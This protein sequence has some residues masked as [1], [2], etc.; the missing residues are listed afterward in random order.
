MDGDGV[1]FFCVVAGRWWRSGGSAL[2]VLLVVPVVV[3]VVLLVYQCLVWDFLPLPLI[4]TSQ[5]DL[6][7]EFEDIT[8]PPTR[9][10]PNPDTHATYTQKEV[11]ALIVDG[12]RLS[13]ASGCKNG[14]SLHVAREV[15]IVF[16]GGAVSSDD[17]WLLFVSHP[18]EF[19]CSSWFA[20]ER[21]EPPTP[22][23]M[24][25]LQSMPRLRLEAA[26]PLSEGGG[27]VRV[28]M[29]NTCSSGLSNR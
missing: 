16:S 14:T 9:P 13:A 2:V 11:T 21:G 10:C 17:T 6:R 24:G 18:T 19:L 5:C 27:V 28:A 25:A 8:H 7:R 23:A 15:E 22:G 20:M 12:E 1:F 29:V 4:F 3:V 26:E